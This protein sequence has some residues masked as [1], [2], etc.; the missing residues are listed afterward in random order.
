METKFC[1]SIALSS[2]QP[3]KDLEKLNHPTLQNAL[4]RLTSFAPLENHL[5]CVDVE[6][7]GLDVKLWFVF[8]QTGKD[9]LE[10]IYWYAERGTRY[11]DVKLVNQVSLGEGS[12]YRVSEAYWAISSDSVLDKTAYLQRIADGIIHQLEHLDV[13]RVLNDTY[14]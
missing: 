10:N 14:C 2:K 4:E 12:E 6:V 1:K 3:A 7:S 11:A 8:S 9:V 13:S 5:R